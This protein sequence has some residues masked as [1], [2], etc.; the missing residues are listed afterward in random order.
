[1]EN[2]NNELSLS[3]YLKSSVVSAEDVLKGIEAK[4]GAGKNS[5]KDDRTYQY[6]LDKKTNSCVAILR[7]LPTKFRS[8]TPIMHRMKHYFKDEATGRYYSEF[9]P[10]VLGWDHKCPVCEHNANYYNKNSDI[11]KSLGED[12]AKKIGSNRSR[13]KEYIANILVVKDSTQP[14]NEGKVFLWIFGPDIYKKITSAMKPSE[15]ELLIGK[16]PIQVFDLIHG[17]NFVLNVSKPGKNVT[18]DNCSFQEPSALFGGDET[19]LKAV[20]DQIYDLSEFEP[21]KTL[22]SYDDLK[23]RFLFVTGVIGPKNDQGNNQQPSQ[24]QEKPK[25]ESTI[26]SPTSTSNQSSETPSEPT[27][28]DSVLNDGDIDEYF[29]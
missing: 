4:T 2:Q 17:S 22:K 16:K 19:Q 26:S 24:D 8:G 27:E 11:Y 3:A 23:Q 6:Q 18:Y 28:K 7:F 13:R 25:Q 1:M 21:A 12:A 5:W 15:Q 14:S 29:K 10:T 20:W 9:C